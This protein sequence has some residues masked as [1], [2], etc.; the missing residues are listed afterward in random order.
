MNAHNPRP[1]AKR[2]LATALLAG[3]VIGALGALLLGLSMLAASE[4]E[5]RAEATMEPYRL[6]FEAQLRGLRHGPLARIPC[7]PMQQA[8][9]VR[10]DYMTLHVVTHAETVRQA[11]CLYRRGLMSRA[12]LASIDT[13]PTR[14]RHGLS[15]VVPLSL[16]VV[17]SALL[18]TLWSI[19][20]AIE[21]VGVLILTRHVRR[22]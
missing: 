7:E 13:Q 21:I 18:L 11:R 3:C 14:L 6:L 4:T 5:K 19:L 22:R 16:Q 12:D 17:P 2:R 15:R 20:L 1:I 10:S 9:K 8:A